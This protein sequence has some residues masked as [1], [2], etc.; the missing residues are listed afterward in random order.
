MTERFRS[1]HPASVIVRMALVAL[2]GAVAVAV[3]VMAMAVVVMGVIMAATAALAMGVVVLLMR[4]G[5]LMAMVMVVIMMLVTMVFM[6][7][8]MMAMMVVAAA[9]A[10]MVVMHLGLRLERALHRRHGAALPAHQ[11]GDRRIVGNIERISGHLGRNVVAAEVP[12][13]AHQPQRVLGADFQQAF[14]CGLHLHEPAIVQLQRVA[15]VQSHRL[16]EFD[17]D[18]QPAGRLHRESVAAAIPMPEAE[19]VDDALGANGGLANDGSG[20]KHVR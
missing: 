13:E 14:G 19:R 20:A 16:V 18:L 4:M 9:V 12:G 7:V 5:L 17:G 8:V 2:R 10:V 11:L 15:I 1:R 3:V 6:V